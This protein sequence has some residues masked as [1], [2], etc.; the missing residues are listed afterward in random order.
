MGTMQAPGSRALCVGSGWHRGLFAL[1]AA[2]L[3]DVAGARLEAGGLPARLSWWDG[4]RAVLDD[5]AL[6]DEVLAPAGALVIAAGV[7]E[8]TGAWIVEQVASWWEA[9]SSPPNGS[10][11]VRCSR[12]DAGMDGLS[13]SVLAGQAGKAL[14]ERGAGPV[15]LE[16]PDW[17]LRMVFV[18]GEHEAVG[19]GVAQPREP[20]TWTERSAPERPYMKPVSLDPR[21]AR[22]LVNL[23][24]PGVGPAASICDP[25]CGT[26]GVLLEAELVGVPAVGVDLDPEMVAGTTANLEWMVGGPPLHAQARRGDAAVL[27]EVLAGNWRLDDELGLTPGARR[28]REHQ[29]DATVLPEI[30]AWPHPIGALAFD[31]PYGRNS[32][33]GDDGWQLWSATL[34]AG[35]QVVAVGGRLVCIVPAAGQARSGDSVHDPSMHEGRV[36]AHPWSEVLETLAT[37]GWVPT[38]LVELPVHGS[39]RRLLLVADRSA[40]QI[41][42]DEW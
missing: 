15:D 17:T 19:W 4:P 2:A 22:V 38:A 34:A 8:F 12:L 26:G 27:S 23:G 28:S 36:F 7:G 37:T 29:D 5:A 24:R 31:P 41:D 20:S 32:W 10:F 42:A 35:A 3:A 1:E 13:P 11:A 40:E 6:V 30:T 9:L 18:G 16:A 14:L 21:L 33:H 25:L 39:L